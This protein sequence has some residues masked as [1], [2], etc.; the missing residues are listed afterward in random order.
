MLKKD[1]QG[2]YFVGAQVERLAQVRRTQFNLAETIRPL[3]KRLR[4][5]TGES[6]SFYVR[7]GGMRVCLFR[8]DSKHAIRHVVEEGARL[9]LKDGV[10]GNVLLAQAG[11]EGP[12]YDKIRKD[13]YYAAVGRDP[14]TASVAVPVTTA[15]G[16][17][18]GAMVVSGLADRFDDKKRKTALKRLTE[19]RAALAD[20]LPAAA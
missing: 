14:F 4:D 7:D 15:S 3:L 2:R 17:L 20:L 11:S 12:V 19:A 13:G 10:V 6:A 16:A 9:P 5:E 1:S 18:V 8:E